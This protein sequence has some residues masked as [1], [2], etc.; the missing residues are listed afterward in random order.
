MS[1]P[2]KIAPA[3]ERGIG[4]WMN[5]VLA[6]LDKAG[7]GLAA[8]PVHDLRV[9]IRRCRSL[10][11]GFEQVDGDASWRR[12]RKA[13]KPLFSA[14]GE[15]RDTQV[16]LE[17][18]E[19]LQP[20]CPAV[21][22]RLRAYC[23]ER[24]AE[25]KTNATR[26]SAEFDTRRWLQ[27]APLLEKRAQ[28]L[29]NRSQVFQVLALERLLEGRRL[30]SQA[31]RRR[32]HAAL[33]QLRIGIKKFRYLV[34]NFLPE[35]HQRWGKDLKEL[36]DLLGEVH[37]L[38]VLAATTRQIRACASRPEA[39]L[40][41]AAIARERLPRLQAYRKKMLGRNSLWQRWRDELPTAGELREAVL[42][43][44]EAWSEAHGPDPA[45]ARAVT[46][47]SLQ[48][49]DALQLFPASSPGRVSPR[50]LLHVAALAH[51][52]GRQDGSPKYQQRSRRMLQR[53]PP[54]PG[55]SEKDLALAGL[56]VRYHRGALPAAQ[57]PYAALSAEERHVVDCLAGIL[58]LAD[59]LTG[60]E[61]GAVNRIE[62][63]P[64]SGVIEIAVAGYHPRSRQAQR[65]AAARHLLEDAC[66]MAILL[67]PKPGQPS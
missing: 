47:L 42:Q 54:P 59:S 50:D 60:Q 40:W 23:L 24:E 66:S 10:A 63:S 14:L 15:L 61:G 44:F 26:A 39:Q 64:Q 35:F 57:P 41:H 6:E 56:V 2:S 9:A 34:E 43:K 13:A 51:E 62:V 17:W 28:R 32:S 49:Y 65:I 20:A 4:Y 48:L 7:A 46:A 36:Q 31:W 33:H 22:E 3:P 5:R 18:M 1:Q 38:D 29:A 25:L 58:R 21:A 45:H 30:Q 12:M 55:W 16:L 37:D 19:K 27:W 8:D 52:V 11:E 53:L 67:R